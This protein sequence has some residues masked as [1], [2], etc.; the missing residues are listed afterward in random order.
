M[1]YSLGANCSTREPSL[2]SSF[3]KYRTAASGVPCASGKVGLRSITHREFRRSIYFAKHFLRPSRDSRKWSRHS[4]VRH[5]DALED[6][7]RHGP[8]EAVERHC[9]ERRS[10]FR[11]L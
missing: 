10:F 3:G 8:T 11:V 7:R 1:S 4:R 2:R 9:H 5:F 6:S